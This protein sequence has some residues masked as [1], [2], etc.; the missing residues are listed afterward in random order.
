MLKA[1]E[2]I[3]QE[4][5]QALFVVTQLSPAL[6]FEARTSICWRISLATGPRKIPTTFLTTSA[7]RFRWESN[8]NTLVAHFTTVS[9]YSPRRLTK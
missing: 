4:S 9:T 8:A 7:G 2:L 3:Q 5:D 6:L 1:F